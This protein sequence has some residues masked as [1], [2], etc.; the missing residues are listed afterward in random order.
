MRVM[1]D[2]LIAALESALSQCAP[3]DASSLP[4]AEVAV[5]VVG[6]HGFAGDAGLL[7]EKRRRDRPP[8]SHPHR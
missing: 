2:Q 7:V 8:A 3:A 1:A 6:E 4:A 5:L